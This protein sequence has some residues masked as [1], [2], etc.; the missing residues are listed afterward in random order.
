MLKKVIN[1]LRG[2]KTREMAPTEGYD[3]WAKYYDAQPGN[4]MLALD[5]EVFSL[6]LSNV[7]IVD[8]QVVDVG[9]GTGRNWNKVLALHPTNLTGYDVSAGMLDK[10]KI[11]YPTA[12]V[13]QLKN[14]HLQELKDES[15]DIIISTLTIAHIP[16]IADAL[17]EWQRVLK[18][19]GEVIITD[20]HPTALAGGGN[21]TFQHEGKTVA[22]KN[23]VHTIK[24]LLEISNKLGWEQLRLEERVIDDSVKSY[25]ADKNALHVFDKFKGSPI[26]FGLHL[27]K[28]HATT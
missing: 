8:K 20:Y 28:R 23:H 27:K 10:L 5:E 13:H 11:K 3:L 14:N 4:L 22:V 19:G 26:I 25:Y 2:N 9:C 24:Q 17:N 7:S 12:T 21:R 18:Y 15:C 6:L 16:D 1:Y